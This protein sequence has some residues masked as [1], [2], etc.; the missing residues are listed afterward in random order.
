MRILPTI[1]EFRL[2]LVDYFSKL[3]K[4][5]KKIKENCNI[6][7]SAK[8][9]FLADCRNHLQFTKY[10]FCLARFASELGNKITKKGEQKRSFVNSTF[11]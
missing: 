8:I 4:I 3:T 11:P 1:G 9:L 5:A 7:D 2:Q 10:T 6:A